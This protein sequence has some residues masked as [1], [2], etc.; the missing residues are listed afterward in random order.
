MWRKQCLVFITI[1][2][3]IAWVH[4][5]SLKDIKSKPDVYLYGEGTGTTVKEA[6]NNAL[7][8]LVSSISTNIAVIDTLLSSDVNGVSEEEFKSSI[9][10][11]SIATLPNV[12]RKVLADEPNAVVLRYMKVSDLQQMYIDRETKI[13]DYIKSAQKLERQIQ[14]DDAIRYYS[15]AYILASVH[16]TVILHTFDGEVLGCATYLPMKIKSM[17]S[18]LK[19]EVKESEEYGNSIVT[20]AQFTYNGHNV[21]SLTFKYF[22]GESYAG[23]AKVRDGIGELDML[24]L[25][26][27]G[28]IDISYEYKFRA[29]AENSSE[30][31]LRNLYAVV[32]LPIIE[33]SATIP[34]KINKRKQRIEHD[35]KAEL[36]ELQTDAAD[37]IAPER[38]V[39]KRRI[40]LDVVEDI[41][42]YQDT[43]YKVESAIKSHN[44]ALAFNCFTPEGYRM[45]E[46]LLTKT[47]KVTLSGESEYSFLKT[48]SC[49]L[50]RSCRVKIKFTNGA[51]FIENLTFRFALDSNKIESVAFA[52]TK[53][54]E[55]D[56]F[57]AAARWSE[58]SRY[59]ILNFLEDYQ[60]AYALKRKEYL[61]QI[62]SDGAIIITGTV[63]KPVEKSAVSEDGINISSVFNKEEVRYT[64]LNKRDYLKR[65][66]AQFKE[67]E[68]IHLTFEDNL[69]RIVNTNAALPDGA[70]FAIQ[71]HQ[72]YSSPVYSDDGYLTLLLNMQGVY[73]IIEVRLWEPNQSNRENIDRFIGRFDF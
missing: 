10:T 71:I 72:K 38:I 43:L 45:F 33:A 22:N 7:A 34:V 60:T 58:I 57:N 40:D 66:D 42:P 48:T 37:Y 23:P 62:F 20:R 69:T 9:Q 19:G 13:I 3:S 30:A 4:A 6:D 15:W 52:L 61:E 56:I 46:T 11:F 28:K 17:L 65:L 8:D 47:G 55:D 29:E 27:D 14:I 31:E 68:Y 5:Q 16:P 73:P 26:E 54:A 2:M 21:S 24:Q 67:R 35:A 50:A 25:P 1:T 44:P 53:K 63:L 70:V 36:P 49:I 39:A 32:P 51:S 59:H 64:Q 12:L 41:T 18:Q